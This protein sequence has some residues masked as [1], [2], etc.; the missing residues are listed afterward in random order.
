MN[1]S[2]R[3]IKNYPR[4]I[5]YRSPMSSMRMNDI[6]DEIYY[7][8]TQLIGYEQDSGNISPEGD[9]NTL[10]ADIT[11]EGASYW[12]FTTD[13][14]SARIPM[15]CAGDATPS[16]HIDHMRQ[17]TDIMYQFDAYKA[18]YKTES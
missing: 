18:T 3:P 17:M 15:L 9:I 13:N 8:L 5:R 7:E 16:G 11:S 1:I 6:W 2:N 14:T 12:S 10:S 4:N